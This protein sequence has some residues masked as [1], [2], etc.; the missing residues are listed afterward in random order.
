MKNK[1][2]SLAITLIPLVLGGCASAPRLSEA[3]RAALVPATV[4]TEPERTVEVKEVEVVRY[5]YPETGVISETKSPNRPGTDPSTTAQD[6]STVTVTSSMDFQQSIAEYDFLHGRIYEVFTSPDHVTDIR[7]APGEAVSGNAAIGDALSWQ[8]EQTQSTEAGQTITHIYVKPT[9]A[10]LETT[11]VV[12]TSQR[13]YYLKLKSFEKMHMVGVQWRYPVPFTF[14]GSAS[15]LSGQAS[16]S[17]RILVD[18]ENT[19]YSYKIQ[20]QNIFWKPTNVFDDG[21][22]TYFVFDPRFSSSAGAPAL[23]LLPSKHSQSNKVQVVNY[24]T[25]GN[26]YIADFVIEDNQAWLLMAENTQ[27]KV[28]RK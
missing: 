18:V 10:G 19:N 25:Q 22:H 24:R 20:G 21:T 17:P 4:F 11:M 6:E 14:A 27:V 3:D 28:T 5:V 1:L 12:P 23:Y 9:L 26:M 8:L 7:L 15:A 16:D 13:T 2:L